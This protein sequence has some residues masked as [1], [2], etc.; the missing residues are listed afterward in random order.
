[1]TWTDQ[2]TAQSE[3]YSFILATLTP[4][5]GLCLRAIYYTLNNHA[6]ACNSSLVNYVLQGICV[7]LQEQINDANNPI[8]LHNLATLKALNL[9]L[10]NE[11]IHIGLSLLGYEFLEMIKQSSPI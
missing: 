1:M 4:D 3:N 6:T 11:N 8:K 10:T 7:N 5:D 2:L 9:I